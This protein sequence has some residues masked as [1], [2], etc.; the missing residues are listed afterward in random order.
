MEGGCK[1]LPGDTGL[2]VREAPLQGE[3]E[4]ATASAQSHALPP[5]MEG[6]KEGR[7]VGTRPPG[8]PGRI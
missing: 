1:R 8:S 3:Q 2:E 4:E 6:G 5:H 7:K